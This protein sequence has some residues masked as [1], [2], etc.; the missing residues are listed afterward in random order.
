MK[1][2]FWTFGVIVVF[3]AALPACT[4]SRYVADSYADWQDAAPPPASEVVYRVF[5]I[6]DLGDATLDPLEPSL[7]LLKSHIDQAGENAAVVVLGDNI[8]CCGL[9]DSGTVRRDT[10]ERRLLAQLR[11]VEDFEGRV[12][13]L[14]GNHDWNDDL[15]G[16]LEAVA[17]QERFVEA[18]LDRGNTFLPDD[19]FPGPVEIELTDRLTMLVIDTSWWIYPH[20]KAFGDTGEYDLEEDANFLLELDDLIKRNDDKD[21]LVV[22]HHPM[23]TNGRHGGVLPLKD[24]LFPLKHL[25]PDLVIPLP[26]VGSIYPLFV[27]FSG[28]RQ[29]LSHPRYQS[30]RLA[31]LQIFNQH[32]SL[33]YAAGHEHSLQYF[34]IQASFLQHHV[35]SGSGSKPLE[36]GRGRGAAFTADASG[37]ATL[38]Y[39]RDGSIWIEMWGTE[40][41]SASGRLVFRTQIKGP[42]RELVDPGVPTMVEAV[43]YSDSTVVMAASERYGAGAVKEF[44]LGEHHRDVWAAPVEAPVLDLGKEAGGLVPRKRGGGQ[45]TISLRLNGTDGH[46]YVLRSIDKDPSVAVPVNLRGTIATEV[47]QDQIASINPYGAFV[48][49]SLAEAAGVYHTN[50]RLVYVPDDPRLGVYT[51]LFAG[52]MAMLEERPNDDMSHVESFGRSKDVVSAPK[53]Y[54]EINGDNDHRI[55]HRAFAR[56]RLFDMLL[57]DWDRH[58]DQWRWASFEPYELDPTLEGEARTDGKIYRP[59]PRDRDFAFNKMDGLLPWMA[60]RIEPKFQDFTE[61][62]GDLKGLNLNGLPQD[63]RLLSPL[64]RNDF[65]EIADSIRAALTDEV[66]DAAVRQWPDPIYALNGAETAR[67]LK[68]RRDKLTDVAEKFYKIHARVPDIVGSNKHERFEITRIDD[69]STQIVVFKTSKKGEKRREIYRRTFLE[70][71][72]KEIRLYGLDGNDTFI[73]EGEV[74]DGILIRAIGG[75]GEDTFV[76]R[77][78]VRGMGKKTRFYDTE[79]GTNWDVGS[80]TKRIASDDDPSVNYYDPDGYEY[81]DTATLVYFGS[82]SDDGIFLGGGVNLVR[83]GFRKYP[84]DASHTFKANFAA[85]TQAINAVYEGLYADVVGDWDAILDASYFGPNNIRNFYG[86]GNDTENEVD[87]REFYQA[88]LRQLRLAPALHKEFVQGATFHF[89]PSF[90]LTDVDEATDRF[91]NQPQAGVSASTFDAQTFASFDV[92]VTLD[93]RDNTVNPVQGFRFANEAQFNVGLRNTEDT[94][95][96]LATD[97]SFYLSPSFRS[98]QLTLALRAGA[99]HNVSDFPFYSASTLGGKSNLRGHRSTRFAGRTSFYQNAELRLELLQF[100]TYLAIGRLGALAF[101]D[102]GRVW[103]EAD[104][105]RAISQSFFEG[106][107]QGY[108]GGLW[109]E[110]FDLFVLTTTAGFSNDDRTVTIQLGFQY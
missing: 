57:S 95:L 11:S 2:P 19:G 90:H 83:Y 67:L 33:I 103:T 82:N 44:L 75:A 105:D 52:T 73:V 10:D 71:E 87:D 39:Y 24:H 54:R 38:H 70:D 48:I 102:N 78:R 107:H 58:Q 99:A 7:A 100:S 88:R 96:R 109:A 49:P 40:D 84:Y 97:L 47:L 15:P 110:F 9:A 23:Y 60:T 62:Y 63:R 53:L 5:L 22:G 42:A 30:L 91:V 31:L 26:I 21:L 3:I 76:D 17:R 69:D 4:T 92:A 77:S 98:P 1:R 108:G 32:E 89:G 65:V 94:F 41:G 51:D 68:I 13:F 59:I 85:R 20:N 80:E 18:Y 14:P 27:R 28:G 43:D 72:T 64:R 93:T 86:L 29:N 106:Y 61:S 25:H 81:D 74:G 101:F 34:P 6:G 45:Q 8:Y 66:I 56:A 104:D 37:F 35:V 50:P 55:D 12:V 36:V 46:E 16:G 79:T